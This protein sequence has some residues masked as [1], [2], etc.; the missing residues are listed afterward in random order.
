MEA[1]KQLYDNLNAGTILQA[2]LHA[3]GSA[4]PAGGHG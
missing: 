4:G 1:E 3:H 2:V